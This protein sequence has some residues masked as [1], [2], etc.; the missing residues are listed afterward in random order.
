MQSH[1]MHSTVSQCQRMEKLH[2][3]LNSGNLAEAVLVAASTFGD[4]AHD[5]G[6]EVQLQDTSLLHLKPIDLMYSYTLY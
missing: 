6:L 3:T 4:V 5:L 2:L 1:P